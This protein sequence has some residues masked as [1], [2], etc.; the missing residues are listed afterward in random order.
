MTPSSI[1]K[2]QNSQIP[3]SACF[4]GDTNPEVGE[5][6]CREV[7]GQE[8]EQRGQKACLQGRLP[9]LILT[10]HDSS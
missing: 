1:N 4:V 8:F 3:F 10:H 2:S 6:E 5:L 9:S 7:I